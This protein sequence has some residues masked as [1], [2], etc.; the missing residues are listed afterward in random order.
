M[1]QLKK[2][3]LDAPESS[4]EFKRQVVEYLTKWISTPEGDAGIRREIVLT[5]GEYPIPSA[6]P[7]LKAALQDPDPDVRIV[8]CESWGKMPNATAAE[9]MVGMLKNDENQDVRLA[10]ARSLG[11]TKDQRAIAA[12]GDVLTEQDPAMQRRAVVSLQNIT[13]QDLG[14]NVD[15]WQK[16][17]KEENPKPAEPTSIADTLKKMF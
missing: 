3:R 2:L 14:N 6:E 1:A 10:A 15:R 11:Q 17:V 12:L 13:G 9:L 16:Y 7:L 5:V 8:A 4:P